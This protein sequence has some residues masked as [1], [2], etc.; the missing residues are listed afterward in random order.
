MIK[1]QTLWTSAEL[2]LYRE[3]TKRLEA[4]N[5]TMRREAV[6]GDKYVRRWRP[7]FGYVA[8]IT[9]GVQGLVIFGCLAWVILKSPENLPAALTGIKGVVE[10]L[11]SHW[12]YAMAV[13]GVA[14]AARSGDKRQ[15]ASGEDVG[16]DPGG[17]SRGLAGLG[18]KIRAIF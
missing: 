4:V 8:A 11:S 13:L 3:G 10:A 5:E 1:L 9:W 2:D 18:S 15:K 12:L 17:L 14:V 7:T 16:A 6:A